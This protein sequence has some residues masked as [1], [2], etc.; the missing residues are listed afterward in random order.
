M[1]V[2]NQASET[3]DKIKEKYVR[4]VHTQAE[5]AARLSCETDPPNENAK[6]IM[7]KFIRDVDLFKIKPDFK[8]L[9]YGHGG[10]GR[11]R[12]EFFV[13]IPDNLE[14]PAPLVKTT[15]P[16]GLW[17]VYTITPEIADDLDIVLE[18]QKN[19]DEYINDQG[20]G[21]RPCHEVYFNPLNILGLKNT[22]LFNAVFN[23]EYFDV[24]QPIKEI[25]KTPDDLIKAA[26]AAFKGSASRGKPVEIDLASMI[27]RGDLNVEYIDGAMKVKEGGHMETPRIFTGPVKIEL[28]AK[29]DSSDIFIG[30]GQCALCF[31][32][33]NVGKNNLVLFN[34]DGGL[35]IFNSE[36]ISDNVFVDIEW[37]L[38]IEQMTVKVN[39][40][41]RYSS[42]KKGYMRAFSEN[43]DFNLSSAVRISTMC[44]AT[45]TVESLRV[46][47]IS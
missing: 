6:A 10:D 24:Y 4:V 36:E 46:T 30:Y 41:L 28:R 22:D 13:T 27:K 33:A 44:G 1:D 16:G 32:H 35:E 43:A 8:Y 37:T 19:N 42:G 2:L 47:E 3:L 45:I 14:V 25:K 7:E 40:E 11:G 18:W 5:T 29:T 38:D 23:P 17:A 39:G 34:P 20:G 31:D 26:Y 9:S 12:S 21:G 15:F